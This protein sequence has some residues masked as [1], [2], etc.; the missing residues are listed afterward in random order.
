MFQCLSSE[1]ICNLIHGFSYFRIPIPV[2]N[3]NR[4]IYDNWFE[5]LSNVNSYL[6]S[7]ISRLPAI[8]SPLV[9]YRVESV[10]QDDSR[11]KPINVAMFVTAPMFVDVMKRINSTKMNFP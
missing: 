8:T 2:S 9:F 7:E 6:P 1:N 4:P 3:D 10:T 11:K 5:Q